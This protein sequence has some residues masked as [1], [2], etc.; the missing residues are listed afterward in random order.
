MKA[1]GRTG[2]GRRESHWLAP[3]IVLWL[4]S[5]AGAFAQSEVEE[6]VQASSAAPLS[7]QLQENLLRLQDQWLVWNSLLLQGDRELAETLIRDLLGT[8]DALGFERLPELAVGAAVR[9]V[10][11]ARD[12]EAEVAAWT[13][14]MAEALDPGSPEVRF[15]GSSVAWI[16]GDRVRAVVERLRG[17]ARVARV[18]FQRRLWL[19]NVLLWLI[20][21]LMVTAVLFVALQLATKGEHVLRDL[22]A[23][24]SFV[25]RPVGLA[26]AVVALGWPLLLPIGWAWTLL[27]WVAVLWSYAS[28]SERWALGVVLLTVGLAP[29]LVGFQLSRVEGRLSPELRVVESIEGSRLYGG[30][31]EDLAR[32][33]ARLPD[34]TAVDQLIGDVEVRLGQDDRARPR[35][36]AVL[37][38]EP[39]NGQAINNLGVFHFNRG[40]YV[41][42][43]EFFERAKSERGAEAVAAYNLS[44][45]YRR[46]L[47]FDHADSNLGQARALDQDAVARWIASG[48][49]AV[50]VDGGIERVDEIRQRLL[51]SSTAGLDEWWRW[52]TSVPAVLGALLL[53]LVLPKLGA[54]GRSGWMGLPSVTDNVVERWARRLI[55]GAVSAETGDGGRAYLAIAAPVSAILLPVGGVLGFRVPWGYD[56]GGVLA[57]SVG[58]GALAVFVTVRALLR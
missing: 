17:Y 35:Y 58:L 48:S 6:A 20:Y 4:M 32:L 9:A 57:W 11:V 53:G 46:L 7:I 19:S 31:F 21:S 49:G 28:S 45:S 54:R 10:E 39:D 15:A 56:P 27:Y 5:S 1:H 36:R 23:A 30:L 18:P 16:G 55:P 34:V 38:R 37:E 52:L 2:G 26:L 33:E 29:A 51:D 13:L 40:E 44:S 22:A 42:A 43:I 3:A 24:F 25:P 8:A 47:E 12:G 14:E 50:T 41:L